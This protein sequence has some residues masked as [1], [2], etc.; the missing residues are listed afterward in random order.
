MSVGD[1]NCRSVPGVVPKELYLIFLDSIIAT[2]DLRSYMS[3]LLSFYTP[4]KNS[5]CFADVYDFTH[6]P[7]RNP[8]GG[9]QA[10]EAGRMIR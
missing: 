6:F 2:K 3:Y 9:P 1:S 4:A 5:L 7:K 8:K 10:K